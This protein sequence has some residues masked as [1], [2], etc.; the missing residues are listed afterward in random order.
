SKTFPRLCPNIR[1]EMLRDGPF[2]K[3]I[4]PMRRFKKPSPP[5]VSN[6]K[7]RSAD[8]VR[9]NLLGEVAER[10]KAAVAKRRSAS[11]P[12]SFSSQILALQSLPRSTDLAAVGSG[13]PVLGARRD[14]F[15]DSSST[16]SEIDVT[17]SR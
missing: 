5:P 15:R 13:R 3:A 10:L 9:F 6:F 1:G 17:P 12:S 4:S 7:L 14:N 11:R 2:F 16:A 8:S